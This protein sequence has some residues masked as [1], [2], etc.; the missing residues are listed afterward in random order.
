[1]GDELTE[2]AMNE[3]DTIRLY[4]SRSCAAKT[5]MAFP[6]CNAC[7]VRLPCRGLFL[8]TPVLAA[9][10]KL[11]LIACSLLQPAVPLHTYN[12]PSSKLTS[13]SQTRS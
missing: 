5:A 6:G 9:G 4:E 7:S 11:P 8:R 13:S 12:L 2:G 3:G 10:I 1:M